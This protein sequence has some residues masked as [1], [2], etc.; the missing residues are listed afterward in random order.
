MS[1]PMQSR[2]SLPF[3]PS[4]ILLDGYASNA[5]TFAGR[6]PRSSETIINDPIAT[7]LLVETALGD[8][9]QFEVLSPEELESL[10]KEDAMLISRIDSV[11]RKLVLE[12]KV[13]DAATSLNRLYTSHKRKSSGMS[14]PSPPM[15]R[16]NSAAPKR[17]TMERSEAELAESNQKCEQLSRELYYLEQRSRQTQMR[18]LQHTAAIL[19][20]TYGNGHRP[21]PREMELPGARPYS[22]E[23]LRDFDRGWDGTDSDKS[24]KILAQG[25]ESLDGFLDELRGGG[26]SKTNAKRREAQQS[27]G[28]RLEELNAFV[29]EIIGQVNPQNELASNP[30]PKSKLDTPNIDGAIFDQLNSLNQGLDEL[31]SE[32]RNIQVAREIRSGPSTPGFHNQTLQL[33]SELESSIKENL[34][35]QK[36]YDDAEDNMTRMLEELNNRLFDVIS[37]S[38]PADATAVPSIPGIEEGPAQQITYAR[39]RLGGNY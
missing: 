38:S 28:R 24:D 23:S 35:L 8:S 30:P 21:N 2:Q 16:K 15:G 6:S 4:T 19:Q 31:K 5:T 11:R 13:R 12:N 39:A 9:K 10:K 32:Q 26:N 22:P 25:A 27:I 14:M 20:I 34:A 1:S 37:I 29:R 18:L 17:E 3:P 33:R 7:H 36:E